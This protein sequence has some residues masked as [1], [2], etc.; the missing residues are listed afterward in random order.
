[1]R[2]FDDDLIFE[3]YQLNQE[4]LGEYEFDNSEDDESGDF[5]DYYSGKSPEVSYG[6]KIYPGRKVDWVGKEGETIKVD[7]DLVS[8]R[9]DNITDPK[10]VHAVKDHIKFSKEK[11]KF[12]TPIADIRIIDLDYIRETQEAYARDELNSEYRIETPF[13]TGDDDVDAYLYMDTDE[14]A[15][16]MGL[17]A[18]FVDPDGNPIMDE[19][20][21]YNDEEDAQDIADDIHNTF[22]EVKQKL[23]E[24]IE[25]KSGDIGKVWAV[26]RDGNHRAWG[27]I[28]SGES[29][30]YVKPLMYDMREKE[31]LNHLL[32]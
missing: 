23:R 5:S 31:G 7:S 27:A 28:L 20:L 4:G 12:N 29:Y 24:A 18:D 14:F 19:I 22:F 13:T 16:K 21:D 2:D 17:D 26:I 25:T 30:I 1:M 9:E 15:E 3:T 32:I 8:S 11:V 10:K 6:Y